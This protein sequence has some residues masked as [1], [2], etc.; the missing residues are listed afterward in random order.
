M[1][2]VV[3][4]ELPHSPSP[5][6]L[7]SQQAKTLT[8]Q[9]TENIK[10]LKRQLAACQTAVQEL[11]RG[12]S[13][14]GGGFD[15]SEVAALVEAAETAA[16]SAA[17]SKDAAAASATS[18][19][20]NA[21]SAS[22]SATTA[23]SA[24]DAAETAKAA[25][26]E[27]AEGAAESAASAEDAKDAAVEAKEAAVAAAESARSGDGLVASFV[28]ANMAYNGDRSYALASLVPSAD[29]AAAT[30]T[31]SATV[32]STEAVASNNFAF[33]NVNHAL[34]AY[35]ASTF[36]AAGKAKTGSFAIKVNSTSVTVYVTI[37]REE[38]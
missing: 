33:E 31:V 6:G 27:S 14:P 2:K 8:M 10:S 4:E 25:A 32:H 15:A 37:R 26:A 5:D 23:A 1:T 11:Q 38:A 9:L 30:Y 20:G 18:A 24:K 36:S 35:S 21:S 29:P 3:V 28:I 17:G 19:A 13:R 16:E 12:G 22:Q 7:S 34:T